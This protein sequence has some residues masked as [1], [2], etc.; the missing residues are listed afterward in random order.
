VH[1]P[2]GMIAADGQTTRQGHDPTPLPEDPSP[3]PVHPTANF[4]LAP[5]TQPSQFI[6]TKSEPLTPLGAIAGE[7]QLLIRAFGGGKA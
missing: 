7:S 5:M 2:K 1:R 3:T 6:L 4:D